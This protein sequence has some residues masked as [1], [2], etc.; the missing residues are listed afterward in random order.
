MHD[1]ICYLSA[2]LVGCF[3]GACLVMHLL[4]DALRNGDIEPEE[5]GLPPFK[6]APQHDR[7]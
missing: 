1:V 4:V 5:L 2:L 7:D 6:R 3:I